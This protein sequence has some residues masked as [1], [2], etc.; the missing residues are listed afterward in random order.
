MHHRI[1]KQF[2]ARDLIPYSNHVQCLIRTTQPIS[3]SYQKCHFGY[4]RSQCSLILNTYTHRHSHTHT[5]ACLHS[6]TQIPLNFCVSIRC[7]HSKQWSN[8]GSQ[9]IFDSKTAIEKI[10]L[11]CS[12]E[13][14]VHV[15]S[16]NNDALS[17]FS[18]TLSTFR[19]KHKKRWS[20]D[21]Q[22]AYAAS[23]HNELPKLCGCTQ[24]N[25]PQLSA[26]LH[27]RFR[28]LFDSLFFCWIIKPHTMRWYSEHNQFEYEFSCELNR[29]KR[30][31][32]FQDAI[33]RNIHMFLH[34]IYM[35]LHGTANLQPKISWN[36]L[37]WYCLLTTIL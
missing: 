31:A 28:F 20:N 7:V 11:L 34:L 21:I 26:F 5:L 36:T 18:S 33:I 4:L 32:Q 6:H 24:L 35:D 23:K 8:F 16:L 22:I 17:V 30:N 10:H 3:Q 15:F 12:L 29:V 37:T 9:F 14:Y 19:P 2:L 25:Y 13:I 27:N 1:S